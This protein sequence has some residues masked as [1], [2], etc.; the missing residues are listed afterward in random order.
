MLNAQGSPLLHQVVLGLRGVDDTAER[1]VEVLLDAC[2]PIDAVDKKGSTVLHL[3]IQL[4]EFGLVEK[5]VAA[6]ADTA[7]QNNGGMSSLHLATSENNAE[8]VNILLAAKADVNSQMLGGQTALDLCRHGDDADE[9]QELLVAAGAMTYGRM[10]MLT[11]QD[12]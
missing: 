1:F 4:G 8:M 7:K 3:A 10:S 12:D 11:N 9:V 5:L 2:V 6:G